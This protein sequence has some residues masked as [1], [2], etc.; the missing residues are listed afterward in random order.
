MKNFLHVGYGNYVAVAK[1]R[2]IYQVDTNPVK[3]KIGVAKQNNTL[4][5]LTKGKKTRSAIMM[6][7][8]TIVLSCLN[9]STLIDRINNI[10]STDE[11]CEEA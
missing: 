9:T 5:D 7:D 2:G 1:I 4:E 11:N 10:S 3:L 6:I 8:G